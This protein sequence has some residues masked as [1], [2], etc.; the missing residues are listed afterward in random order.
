[1][2]RSVQLPAGDWWNYWTGEHI[3]GGAEVSLDASLDS[4]PLLVRGG[5]IV[6][7]GPVLQ[8]ANEPSSEPITLTIYPGADGRFTFYDDDGL[9]FAYEHND[10]H[11]IDL[12]W[13]DSAGTLTLTRRKSSRREALHFQVKLVGKDAKT[14]TLQ[15]ETL[16]L[17][18]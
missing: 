3:H 10:F 18:L 2:K 12:T 8:Y 5:S 13:K 7:S 4:M 15:G 16:T 9:T 14:V 17:N 1:V 11:A 6:P